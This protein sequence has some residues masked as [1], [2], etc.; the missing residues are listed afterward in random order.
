M[1]IKRFFNW[2]LDN[3]F[4]VFEDFFCN[5]AY[6]LLSLL[7]VLYDLYTRLIVNVSLAYLDISELGVMSCK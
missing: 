4:Y 1:F 5:K 7:S 6:Y 3:F 2:L